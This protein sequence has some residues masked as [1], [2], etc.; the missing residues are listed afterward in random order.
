MKTT[1]NE[2]LVKELRQFLGPI[3]EKNERKIVISTS[4]PWGKG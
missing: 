2:D 1:L 4:L 3:V